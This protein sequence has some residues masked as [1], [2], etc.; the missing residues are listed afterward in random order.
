MHLLPQMEVL[1][2]SLVQISRFL[3]CS[4]CNLMWSDK[5]AAEGNFSLQLSS[6]W[7]L[8]P[9]CIIM[10]VNINWSGSMH[11][12]VDQKIKNCQCFFFHSPPIF[13]RSWFDGAQQFWLASRCTFPKTKFINLVS[14][15]GLF[16]TVVIGWKTFTHSLMS[17]E[18]TCSLSY[19]AWSASSASSRVWKTAPSFFSM[20][21]PIIGFCKALDT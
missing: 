5:S 14:Y 8:N 3:I 17:N 16:F 2:V 12:N 10:G 9:S 21:T 18:C 19:L 7:H 15:F 20:W 11:C 6:K 13:S 1:E 4:L